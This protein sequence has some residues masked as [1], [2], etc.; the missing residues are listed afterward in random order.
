MKPLVW[1]AMYISPYSETS[2][3]YKASYPT[4]LYQ[5]VRL[6]VALKLIKWG[7]SLLLNNGTIKIETS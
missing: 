3:E 4:N 2:I 1:K 7:Y 5:K 6:A